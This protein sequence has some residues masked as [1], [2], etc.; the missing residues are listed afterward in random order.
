MQVSNPALGTRKEKEEKQLS[1]QI[2]DL[3]KKAEDWFAVGWNFN[4]NSNNLKQAIYSYKKAIEINP[5]HM[6]A[7]NNLALIFYNSNQKEEAKKYFIIAKE[8]GSDIAYRN[9]KTLF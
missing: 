6:G 9:L 2:I 3:F 1:A 4:R 5:K 8:L 7:Y